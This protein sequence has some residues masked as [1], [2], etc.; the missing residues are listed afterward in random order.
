MS[1]TSGLA[2]TNFGIKSERK[3]DQVVFLSPHVTVFES[4]KTCA[5]F[6]TCE[7]LEGALIKKENRVPFFYIDVNVHRLQRTHIEHKQAHRD[8]SLA[9]PYK[10]RVP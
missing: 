10:Q 5:L 3:W 7:L 1:T 9:E 6:S 2:K 8:E 4:T